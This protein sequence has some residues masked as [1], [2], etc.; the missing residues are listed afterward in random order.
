VRDIDEYR[1]TETE[2]ETEHSRGSSV[3]VGPNTDACRDAV[4]RDNFHPSATSV[5]QFYFGIDHTQICFVF[6]SLQGGYSC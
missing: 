4:A 3:G 5:T 6:K 2:K 1:E